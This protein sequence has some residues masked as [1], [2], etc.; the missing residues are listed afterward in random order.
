M[1]I[2][3][4]CSQNINGA[5]TVSGNLDLPDDSQIQLG[6]LS[7]GDM[8]LYHVSGIGS[9]VLNKTDDLR[10]INQANDKDII[11]GLLS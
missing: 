8:K 9:Y 1:A 7:G 10:I 4:Y 3:Y 2:D 11:F 5:L 6:N